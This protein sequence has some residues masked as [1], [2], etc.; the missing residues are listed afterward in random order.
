MLNISRSFA[1]VGACPLVSVVTPSWNGAEFI[2]RTIS[3]VAAQSYR[4]IEYIV[5]D[6]GSTDGTLDIVNKFGATVT[7]CVSEAD[8]GMYD[9]INKGIKMTSGDIIAYIN[10]DD[11]Y[12][13][14]TIEYVVRFFAENPDV[15]VV[16]GDLNFIDK[17]DR[18][19]FRQSYPSFNRASFSTM[20]YA[21]IGQ[22]AAFWRR[23]V[24]EQ[25]GYFDISLKMAA[26]FEFFVR[27]GAVVRF[28]HV[29]KVLSAFRIHPKS[30]TSRQMD[31]SNREVTEIH[32][33]YLKQ[34]ARLTNA[35]RRVSGDAWFKFINL[36]N[37]PRRLLSQITL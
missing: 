26:D 31:I 13:P 12:Y 15:D 22:P 30:M 36:P 4:N 1:Q 29:S 9:A 18:V 27:A 7:N 11:V 2:E 16:Y 6:G 33:R 17:N 37:W 5:V 25:I 34:N 8:R 14:G 24:H 3:S 19:L 20:N 28:R 35:L 10:S 21:A 32:R 23:R